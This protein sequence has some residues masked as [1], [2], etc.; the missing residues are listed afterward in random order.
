M[1][2]PGELLESVNRPEM[3]F[4]WATATFGVYRMQVLVNG[5]QVAC[6]VM[7]AFI[8]PAAAARPPLPSHSRGSWRG[9][10]R[11]ALRDLFQLVLLRSQILIEEFIQQKCAVTPHRNA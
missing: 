2:G 7:W 1:A 6:N 10:L 11:K 3:S 4:I 8:L 5:I 9:Y